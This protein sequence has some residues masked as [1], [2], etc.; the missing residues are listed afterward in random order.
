M[1]CLSACRIGTLLVDG[2]RRAAAPRARGAVEK[3]MR[4]DYKVFRVNASQ[5]L[6]QEQ[7]VGA[8]TRSLP[9]WVATPRLRC[10]RCREDSSR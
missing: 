3:K 4:R 7:T 6:D 8:S 2:G 10:T 9:P 1:R 5:V